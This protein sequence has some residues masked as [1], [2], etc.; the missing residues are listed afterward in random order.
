MIIQN[1]SKFFYPSII[2]TLLN[3]GSLIS[4]IEVGVISYELTNIIF[5]N[6]DNLFLNNRI[7]YISD[8]ENLKIYERLNYYEEKVKVKQYI[9][10]FVYMYNE[11]F[12]DINIIK[13]MLLSSYYLVL[14]K[15]DSIFISNYNTLYY[16]DEEF[17]T[18][19]E[20]ELLEFFA[21]IL[22]IIKSEIREEID[23]ISLYTNDYSIIKNKSSLRPY[24]SSN[25]LSQ[26]DCLTD[27]GDKRVTKKDIKNRKEYINNI[28]KKANK[29][30]LES[31]EKDLITGKV[32]ERNTR[33][34][35]SIPN[36]FQTVLN[37]MKKC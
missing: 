26:T 23:T 31:Y 14:C 36:D 10:K 21:Y 18:K 16:Y 5:E 12:R 1:K 15:N 32:D 28:I 13:D 11:Y 25:I 33:V 2:D 22:F 27:Y 20:T 17:K 3:I 24:E 8:E 37:K 7:K 6:S 19:Y 34:S 9:F 29:K 30:F 4:N 35:F